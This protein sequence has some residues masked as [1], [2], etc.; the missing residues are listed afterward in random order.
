MEVV[1]ECYNRKEFTSSHT[2]LSLWLAEC[3]A[4]IGDHMFTTIALHLRQYST[5]TCCTSIRVQDELSSV[6]LVG[7]YWGGGESTF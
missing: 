5:H 2:I 1:D 4:C 7:Q 6:D 3:F